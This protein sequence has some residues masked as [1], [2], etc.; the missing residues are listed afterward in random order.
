MKKATEVL[1]KRRRHWEAIKR[2]RIRQIEIES[3]KIIGDSLFYDKEEHE[4][5]IEAIETLKNI[6]RYRKLYVNKKRIHMSV[7]NEETLGEEIKK[8][9]GD[10]GAHYEVYKELL[11]RASLAKADLNSCVCEY[12]TNSMNGLNTCV[13]CG[14]TISVLNQHTS[15]GFRYDGCKQR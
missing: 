10:N 7:F 3:D 5:V 8:T 15:E 9:W 13:H 14:K 1:E 2:E 11:I 12:S 4:S 6:E